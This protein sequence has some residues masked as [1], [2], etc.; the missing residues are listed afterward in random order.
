MK[1]SLR[2]IRHTGV[3]RCRQAYPTKVV[4]ECNKRRTILKRVPIKRPPFGVVFLLVLCAQDKNPGMKGWR[5]TNNL[6]ML[7]VDDRRRLL[8]SKQ[9]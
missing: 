1:G 7:F 2:R 3:C 8:L 5:K 6:K 4:S 9:A